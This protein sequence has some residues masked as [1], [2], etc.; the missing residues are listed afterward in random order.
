MFADFFCISF[1]YAKCKFFCFFYSR[2]FALIC[3]AKK[4]EIRKAKFRE[5]S[6]KILRRK[7]ANIWDKKWKKELIKILFNFSNFKVENSKKFFVA[8]NCCNNYGFRGFFS[9]RYFRIFSWNFAYF[10]LIHYREKMQSFAKKFA[11]FS[12]FS[13]NFS[14]PGKWKP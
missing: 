14:F 3:F 12:I 2:N 6:E 10:R 5:K 7:K 1:A 9:L 4:C 8:I 13:Q 11:F